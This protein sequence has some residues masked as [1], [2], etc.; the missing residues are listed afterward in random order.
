[1][2]QEQSIPVSDGS[3][4]QTAV[5]WARERSIEKENGCWI[6]QNAVSNNGY[7]VGGFGGRTNSVYR[8]VWESVNGAISDGLELHHEC[9]ER[10]CVN[11]DHLT[12]IT[13][14]ENSLISWND[15]GRAPSCPLCL[16]C[17]GKVSQQGGICQSCKVARTAAARRERVVLGIRRYA[18]MYG[19]PPSAQCFNKGMAR[20][21]G[22]LDLVERYESGDWPSATSVVQAFGSWTEALL[23]AGFDCRHQKRHWAPTP[24]AEKEAA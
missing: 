5:E 10:R 20:K 24:E 17:R 13:H 12:P 7:P 16:D 2:E 1:M 19:A 23:A 22:R 3:A 11:P 6:W 18:A 14:Y 21:A 4:T 9:R 8:I 15:R